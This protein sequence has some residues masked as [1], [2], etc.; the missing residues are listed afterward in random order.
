MAIRAKPGLY[1][2]QWS[3]H[4][5]PSCSLADHITC[6]SVCL[7]RQPGADACAGGCCADEHAAA[8]SHIDS[9]Q[10]ARA[11]NSAN[12]CADRHPNTGANGDANGHR[13][14]AAHGYPDADSDP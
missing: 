6:A 13:N 5:D 7:R 1:V 9:N 2:H 12:T 4:Y 8:D 14:A 3:S 11:Y 10:Q